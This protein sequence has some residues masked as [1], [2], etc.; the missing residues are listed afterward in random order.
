VTESIIHIFI[1][2]YIVVTNG[3][4]L[5]ME[6]QPMDGAHVLRQDDAANASVAE[7]TSW[8]CVLPVSAVFHKELRPL[9][10][11]TASARAMRFMIPS[12]YNSDFFC[13]DIVFNS[14][15]THSI[16]QF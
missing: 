2:T 5:R 10:I 9:L 14:K 13:A 15:T 1:Y 11:A 7:P 16:H 3:C 6:L 4:S 8:S 12:I